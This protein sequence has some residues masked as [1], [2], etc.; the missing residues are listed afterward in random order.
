MLVRIIGSKKNPTDAINLTEVVGIE[1]ESIS[2]IIFLFIRPLLWFIYFLLIAFCINSMLEVSV[3]TLNSIK[4][5][6]DVILPLDMVI[7]NIKIIKRILI[8]SSVMF[9]IEAGNISSLPCK[10]PLCTLDTQT[11]GII[12]LMLKI[13]GAKDLLCNAFA[14][15][16]EDNTRIN[17]SIIFIIKPIKYAF[18]NKL[19]LSYFSSALILLIDIGK[20]NWVMLIISI[21]VGVINVYKD[22][23]L[24]PAILVYIIFPI[25]PKTFATAP[26]T[27]R[28]IIFLISKL[29]LN[30][31][32]VNYIFYASIYDLTPGGWVY[33]IINNRKIS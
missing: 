29:F 8:I 7:G 14:M 25:I 26:E 1:I 15:K 3:I 27:R 20:L 6:T 19:L 24:T 18:F 9:V 30:L 2:F 22:T 13:A 21:N 23:T 16:L 32:I 31:I 12:T 11:N 28:I 5:I 4:N 10:K 17:I 33:D